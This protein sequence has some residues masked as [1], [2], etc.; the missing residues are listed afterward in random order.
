VSGA[1][2]AVD[3]WIDRQREAM[4]RS[5]AIRRLLELGLTCGTV[6]QAEAK[7]AAAPKRGKGKD[8]PAHS[9][10]ETTADYWRRSLENMARDAM[11]MRPYWT[12]QFGEWQQF[13]VPSSLVTPAEQAAE[14]WAKIAEQLDQALAAAPKRRK[15]K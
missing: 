3:K 10:K 4:S 2:A 7:R 8:T 5:E 15:E 13:E 9:D 6:T 1:V 14:E 12:R 11:S